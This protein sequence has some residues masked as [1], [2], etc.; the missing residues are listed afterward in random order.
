MPKRKERVGEKHGRLTVT[1]L[2]VRTKTGD[3]WWKCKCQCGT[4][5]D[6]R[7]GLLSRTKSCGCAKLKHNLSNKKYGK[8]SILNKKITK[9]RV[10]HWL[11]RCECGREKYVSSYSL[12]AGKSKGCGCSDINHYYFNAINTETAYLA[13][14]IGA[15]GNLDDKRLRLRINLSNKDSEYLRKISIIMDAEGLYKLAK[16]T[17]HL[18]IY[19]S[20]IYKDL[21]NNFGLKPRKTFDLLPP[22]NLSKE[23]RI[24]Y[25]AGYIDGDGSIVDY[26]NEAG[27]LAIRIVGNKNILEYFKKVLESDLKMKIGKLHPEKRSPGIYTLVI[28][29]KKCIDLYHE[30]LKDVPRKMLMKRKWFKLD[31]YMGTK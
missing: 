30:V 22:L 31:K 17:C 7:A 8:W 11:A 4:S 21:V 13:G 29:G 15:D 24:A 3:V 2:S 16:K 10:I 5:T 20:Q 28:G 12:R 18:E 25:M 26:H 23:Q 1:A 6:V 14:F 9:G 27:K 19:S